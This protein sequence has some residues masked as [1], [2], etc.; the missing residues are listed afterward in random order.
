MAKPDLDSLKPQR[1][2]LQSA[3]DA[4]LA[5]LQRVYPYQAKVTFYNPLTK[6]HTKGEVVDWIIDR[7]PIP[8]VVLRKRDRVLQEVLCSNITDVQA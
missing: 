4:L 6:R 1:A 2:S 8:L 7:T 5:A 3:N